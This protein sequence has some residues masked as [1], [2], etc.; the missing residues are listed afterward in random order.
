MTVFHYFC[1]QQTKHFIWEPMKRESLLLTK[2]QFN[3]INRFNK[4]FELID[5]IQKVEENYFI[6]TGLL[7][8][9]W[10]CE[11]PSSKKVFGYTS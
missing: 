3:R 2:P 8:F 4:L 9:S 6:S 7:K 11:C 10:F 5:K 1:T